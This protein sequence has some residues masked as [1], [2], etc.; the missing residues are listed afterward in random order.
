MA[1]ACCCK[2]TPVCALEA[3]TA[4]LQTLA[5]SS[6]PEEPDLATAA[7]GAV[8]GGVGD[9]W[10]G[11]VAE[12]PPS[13]ASMAPLVLTTRGWMSTGLACGNGAPLQDVGGRATDS[14]WTCTCTGTVIVGAETDGG[15]AACGRGCG[16]REPPKAAANSEREMKP[17]WLRSN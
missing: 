9:L 6:P 4:V 12:A 5:P 15:E 16:S 1:P 3:R 11:V 13:L 17:S 8:L 2:I 7:P 14:D 10:A